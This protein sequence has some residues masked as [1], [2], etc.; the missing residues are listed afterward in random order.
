MMDLGGKIHCLVIL[1]VVITLFS[2]IVENSAG[3]NSENTMQ[4]PLRD[5]FDMVLTNVTITNLTF[6]ENEPKEGDNITIHV[7]VRNNRTERI[8]N[9]NI[10]LV[11]NNQNFTVRQVSINGTTTK[12][13]YFYWEAEGGNQI[14]RANLSLEMPDGRILESEPSV[15]EIWVE[16]EPIG[17]VYSPILA[18]FLVFVIIFGSAVIPSLWS[19]LT[20]RNSSREKK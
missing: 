18:L 10:S 7:T 1:V 12:T 15:K 11:R 4:Q 16:P 14:F 17:D 5:E 13:F 20:D 3:V 6:S 2:P 9:L 8:E 19:S